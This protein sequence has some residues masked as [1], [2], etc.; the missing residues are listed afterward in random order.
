MIYGAKYINEVLIPSDF[1]Q[2]DEMKAGL[3]NGKEYA[4]EIKENRSGGNHRRFFRFINTAYDMQS[5]FDNDKLF[6]KYIEMKAGHYDSFIA[7]N[8]KQV[9]IPKSIS[10]HELNDEQEFRKLFKECITAYL[11]FYN[12]YQG[13]LSE[14]N[15]YQIIDFD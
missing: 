15:F 1:I 10:W 9:Y 6:R 5:H 13:E 4:I 7:P 12:K 2:A 3:I 14:N 11:N 8:G